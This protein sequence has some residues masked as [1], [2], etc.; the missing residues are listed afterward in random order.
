MPKI[1]DIKPAWEINKSGNG[2]YLWV[3]CEKCG[4]LRWIL[5][6]NF[7]ENS[8]NYCPS[9]YPSTIHHANEIRIRNHI[10]KPYLDKT[11]G[12]LIMQLKKDDFF[13][14]TCDKY[15]R[16]RLNRLIMAKYL[17]RNLCPWEEV[18]HKNDNKLDNNID[19]LELLTHSEHLGITNK[20]SKTGLHRIGGCRGKFEIK[21][22]PG[23]GA[24]SDP[25]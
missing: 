4:V 10:F 16:V 20:R 9:C 14:P 8:R 2:K 1:G 6:K 21:K 22:A 11:N 23:S 5:Y 15:G 19:N 12:Y 18:H 24:E 13:R 7:I 17:G 3:P 25:G